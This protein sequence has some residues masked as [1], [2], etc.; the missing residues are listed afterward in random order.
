LSLFRFYLNESRVF[1]DDIIDSQGIENTPLRAIPQHP[2]IIKEQAFGGGAYSCV[3]NVSTQ[4][5]PPNG[6]CPNM[7]NTRCRRRD[8]ATTRITTRC[9][10]VM[11][12]SL[13]KVLGRFLTIKSIT[14]R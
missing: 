13:S 2:Y 6:T 10:A 11:T 1:F 7:P 8:D 5:P 14:G 9:L 3:N 4:A 12:K